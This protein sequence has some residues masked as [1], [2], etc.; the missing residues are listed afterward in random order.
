MTAHVMMVS[1]VVRC[2]TVVQLLHS[3]SHCQADVDKLVPTQ[4]R[5]QRTNSGP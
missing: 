1:L 3:N 4:R 5:S 2:R